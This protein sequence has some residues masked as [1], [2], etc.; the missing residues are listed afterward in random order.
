MCGKCCD[1]RLQQK[2]A[3]NNKNRESTF[4]GKA[5]AGSEQSHAAPYLKGWSRISGMPRTPTALSLPAMAT[6]NPTS[7]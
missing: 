7:Q 6:G 5:G 2:A 1:A 4:D 3:K